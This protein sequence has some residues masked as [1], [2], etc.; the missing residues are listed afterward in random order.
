M[1]KSRGDVAVTSSAT[2]RPFRQIGAID[3]PICS[4]SAA[5][6]GLPI[7]LSFSLSNLYLFLLRSR[8]PDPSLVDPSRSRQCNR[9]FVSVL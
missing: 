8:M 2:E 5:F 1:A 7:A 4:N 9:R 3:A 6:L